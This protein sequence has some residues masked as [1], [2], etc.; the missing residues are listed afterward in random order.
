MAKIIRE[1]GIVLGKEIKAATDSFVSNGQVVEARPER[2]TVV[3]ACGEV[4][5]DDGIPDVLIARFTVEMDIYEE[6]KYLDRV[7]VTY[8]YNG[9][10]KVKPIEIIGKGE[11]A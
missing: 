8:Q 11:C 7:E 4:R 10:N 2:P 9:E 3:V 5:G 6:L 1:S